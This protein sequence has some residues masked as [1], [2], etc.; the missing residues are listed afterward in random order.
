MEGVIEDERREEEV[1]VDKN[2]LSTVRRG[3]GC[4]EHLWPFLN[5]RLQKCFTVRPSDAGVLGTAYY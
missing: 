2:E 4:V 3:D 1:N 5:V